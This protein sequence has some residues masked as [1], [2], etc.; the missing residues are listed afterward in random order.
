MSEKKVKDNENVEA[1]ADENTVASETVPEKSV[2]KLF[3]FGDS[4]SE[5]RAKEREESGEALDDVDV[6]RDNNNVIFKTNDPIK[7]D[8]KED[9]SNGRVYHNLIISFD[10]DVV[11]NGKTFNRHFEV[12]LVPKN[13]NNRNYNG[14]GKLYDIL[15]LICGDEKDIPLEILRIERTNSNT[16]KKT[17]TYYPRIS[18]IDDNGIEFWLILQPQTDGDNACWEVLISLYKKYEQ[19]Y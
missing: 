19:L 10:V 2:N 14:A 16:N 8:R 4:Y 9:T 11:R 13:S 6:E 7:H 3:S 17:V 1:V 5:K 15:D 18:C 12:N